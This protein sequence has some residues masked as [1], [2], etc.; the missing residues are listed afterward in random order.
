[1]FSHVKLL[2]GRLKK[3]SPKPGFFIASLKGYKEWVVNNA[4][5]GCWA[6]GG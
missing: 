1:M 6:A 5:A 2:G 3:L 4:N